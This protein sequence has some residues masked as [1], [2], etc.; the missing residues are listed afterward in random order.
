MIVPEY[1]VS[2]LIW[3]VPIIAMTAFFIKKRLLSPEKSFA[4]IVT[5]VALATT[6]IALDLLFAEFFF[7]FPMPGPCSAFLLSVFP[8][9]NSCFT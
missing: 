7:R 2:L 5:V 1:T 9:R 3:I 6:G 4:L 8:L